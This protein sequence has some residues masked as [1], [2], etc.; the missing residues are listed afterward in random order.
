[1]SEF[2]K[3]LKYG[4][5]GRIKAAMKPFPA[6]EVLRDVVPT[7]ETFQIHP[8]YRFEVRYCRRLCCS[9]EYIEHAEKNVIAEM[10]EAIYGDFRQMLIK[11]ERYVYEQETCKAMDVIKEIM[12]EVC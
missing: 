12:A 4:V 7:T 8:E 11:L 9:P 10:K 5:T 3:H 1:M 6:F 2:I